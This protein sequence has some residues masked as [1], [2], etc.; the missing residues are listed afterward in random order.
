MCV[1][2]LL[3]VGG[4]DCKIISEFLDVIFEFLDE[5]LVG[6]ILLRLYNKFGMR[7]KLCFM[8]FL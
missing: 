8:N 6:V 2:I 5:F 4:I 3:F 7:G 1:F